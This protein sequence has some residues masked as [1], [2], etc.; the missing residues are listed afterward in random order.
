MKIDKYINTDMENYL[1]NS[2]HLF[3]GLW[4]F[5]W[6]SDLVEGIIE[7]EKYQMFSMH[8]ARHRMLFSFNTRQVI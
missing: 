6:L 1:Q 5:I 2:I 8:K 4:E 3:E 7:T